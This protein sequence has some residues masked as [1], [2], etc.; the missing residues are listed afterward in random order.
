MHG[1]NVGKAPAG[2][3]DGNFGARV[4]LEEKEAGVGF[5]RISL[6]FRGRVDVVED[7][8]AGRSA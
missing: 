4:A 8:L 7:L 5:G 6:L 1:G 3:N 2:V